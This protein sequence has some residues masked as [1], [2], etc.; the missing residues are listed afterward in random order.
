MG[1]WAQGILVR[2]L[3]WSGRPKGIDDGPATE[4]SENREGLWE[5]FV[6]DDMMEEE[7]G[8]AICLYAAF[9]YTSYIDGLFW[10]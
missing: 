1:S 7:E 2:L 10:S 8:L 4:P 3:I 5:G 6:I 9:T